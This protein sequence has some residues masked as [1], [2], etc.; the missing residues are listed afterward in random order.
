MRVGVDVGGTFTDFVFVDAAGRVA[1]HKVPST[2]D[3][4][5]RAILAG[6]EEAARLLGL[7]EPVDALV[8]G[9]TVATNAVLER[10]GARTALVATAGFGDAFLVGR[11][12]RPALYDLD[13]P[14]PVPLVAPDDV[15]EV[16]ERLGPEGTVRVALDPARLEP[17]RRALEARGVQSV[18][19]CLLYAYLD[20]SHEER[21]RA[22]LE[23]AGLSVS[24]SSRVLPEYREFERTSTTVV[25]AYV[26]PVMD[27]YIGRLEASLPTRHFRIMQSNGGS[28]APGEAR[29]V[30]VHTILSGPAGGVAGAA[31]LGRRSGFERFVTFDMG[32]TSTDVA[33]HDGSVSVTSEG[34]IEGLP[35]RVP[36]LDIHTVG[37][38]GGSLARLDAGGALVVGPESAGAVPGPA[39]YGRGTRAAVTDANAVLGRLSPRHFLGGRM[40]LHV[41]RAREAVGALAAH[42]AVGLEEAASGII[43]VVNSAME[44][45]VRVISVERGHDVRD[46][47][48]FCF[49]GAG[50][51]HAVDLA[52]ALEMRTVVVPPSP[53][54][55]SA[56]GVL[57]ADVVKD[58]GRTVLAAGN[59]P[60]AVGRALDE[61]ERDGLGVLQDEGCPASAVQIFRSVDV[62]YAGQSYEIRV[63]W[64]E[65]AL[66]DFHERHRALFGHGDEAA[67]VEI[68]TARVRLA[69]PTEPV[70]PPLLE[71]AE[72]EDATGAVV[73]S[74]P[75]WFG[76]WLD[77]P[78]VERERLRAGHRVRGPAVVVEPTST[79]VI[80]PGAALVVDACG[81]LVVDVGGLVP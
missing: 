1:Y 60:R 68:V 75:A 4:P 14:L 47:A 8:H 71:A 49:G 33:L 27:A 46:F 66:A 73:G 11:Q 56:C 42:M 13:V 22:A 76:E 61:L 9:S 51:L 55:L 53:G 69:V 44:R 18:A 32:G 50:G 72:S 63:P 59:D 25:N 39:C 20:P 28:M 65:R 40:R 16:D 64:G 77:V 79:T 36:M 24:L 54:T 7:R 6:L 45:A 62:R 35:I 48:L 41:D 57:N 52:R 10:K 5:G 17:L 34:R 19:V 3:D 43:R 81:S 2:P 26:A 80:P 38:G 21:V 67:A 12:V 70:L 15:L 29:R 37:A 74:Q 78:V 30:P 58:L 23:G 31:A